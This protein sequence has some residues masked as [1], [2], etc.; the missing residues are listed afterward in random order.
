MLKGAK[1]IQT[2][3]KQFQIMSISFTSFRI[4]SKGFKQIQV[5]VNHF[6]GEAADSQESVQHI[7]KY[8]K[9]TYIYIYIYISKHI[10]IYNIMCDIISKYQYFY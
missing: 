6:Q 4:M 3:P 9:N 1:T 7:A 8:I 5:I 10:Q 2:I